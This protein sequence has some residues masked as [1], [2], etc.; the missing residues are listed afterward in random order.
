MRD[1]STYDLP[2]VIE[3]SPRFFFYQISRAKYST[4]TLRYDRI[5]LL[6]TNQST[7]GFGTNSFWR[8][9]HTEFRK[10]ICHDDTPVIAIGAHYWDAEMAKHRLLK[11]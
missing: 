11:L 4:A 2:R 8:K 6:L 3:K 10:R 7:Q 1:A 5:C 9:C